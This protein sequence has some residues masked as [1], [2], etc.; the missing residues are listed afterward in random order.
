MSW[1]YYWAVR[2]DGLYIWEDN[3][4]IAKIPPEQFVFI[5]ANVRSQERVG[6]TPRTTRYNER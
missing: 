4:K 5:M 6:S 2:D 3:V 1:D